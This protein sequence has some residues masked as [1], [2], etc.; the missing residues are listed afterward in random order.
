MHKLKQYEEQRFNDGEIIECFVR[1][2]VG[3]MFE[4]ALKGK[5]E[6]RLLLGLKKAFEVTYPT[7]TTIEETT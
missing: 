7:P 6:R 5:L 3:K 2:V 1:T 4:E